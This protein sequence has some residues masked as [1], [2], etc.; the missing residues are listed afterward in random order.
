MANDPQALLEKL[1]ALENDDVGE[2]L[3]RAFGPYVLLASLAK[4]GMGE[5]FL[6]KSGAV[7]GFEKVCVV[8]TLRPH[9]TDDREYVARFIDE[10]RVVVQLGHRN[11]CQVFDVGR[12]GERYYLAMEQIAGKDLRTVVDV[13]ADPVV[14]SPMSAARTARSVKLASLDAQAPLA[15]TDPGSA[16]L[17][18]ALAVHVM[19][20]VLD[21]LDYAHRF[22]DLNGRALHLVHRDV[23]PQNVMVSF[24]GE[25]KLIDFGLAASEVK[26]EQTSPN[27]VMGKLAYMSPEQLRAEKLDARADLFAAAVM[28]TE[29]VTGERYYQGLSSYEVWNLAAHGTHRPRRF[30]QIPKGL[31]DILD[32]AL[33][34]DA[35]DRHPSCAAFRDALVRWRQQQGLYADAANLRRLM[36]ERFVDDIRAHRELLAGV[37]STPQ[38]AAPAE[39]TKSFARS[40]GNAPP[41]SPSPSSPSSSSSP[42]SSSP[43]PAA[44]EPTRR[45]GKGG[46]V[47]PAI[48]DRDPT[49]PT[50]SHPAPVESRRRWA[51]GVAAG[52]VVGLGGYL[53]IAALDAGAVAVADGGVVAVAVDAGVVAVAPV[54]VDAGAVD[55][56]VVVDAADAGADVV[57]E[58]DE[59]TWEIE[60]SEPGRPP[61]KKPKKPKKPPEPSTT[62]TSTSTA[63]TTT[64]P[65]PPPPPSKAWADMNMP[66]RFVA[67]EKA[68]ARAS[69][70]APLLAKRTSWAKDAEPDEMVAFKEQMRRCYDSCR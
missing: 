39:A 69:C 18:L 3:P 19:A 67:L 4:G 43:P 38:L 27:V 47:H 34:K 57:E 53:G 21:A 25:V 66:E 11:I 41:S 1:D 62:A 70:A 46:D 12:V 35:A 5:V 26:L 54:V 65:P 52:V 22:V 50:R 33:A 61:K 42:T 68:C 48:T 44:P 24:E 15:Q 56:A 49:E 30:A 36:Q 59:D 10:A 40:V 31:R 58:E 32:R 37:H 13:A 20:E 28:L 16:R 23:S 8:K 55:V 17:D 29:M 51:L 9:L 14:T 64:E 45:H 63:S 7:V 6:A 2:R 60:L